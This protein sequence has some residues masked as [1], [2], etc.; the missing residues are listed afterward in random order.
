MEE[1]WKDIPDYE[2]LYQ[3]SSLGR[4][5][6]LK[7]QVKN[8]TGSYNTRKEKLLKPEI[9]NRGYFRVVLCKNG[10]IKRFS[11]HQLIAITFLNHKPCGM[12]L[13]VDHIDNNQ[14]NNKLQNLQ[15][16]TSRQNSSKEKRGNCKYTGVHFCARFGRWIA[17]IHI[18][19]KKRHLGYFKCETAAHLAYQ[20]RLN[21][22]L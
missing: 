8:P 2:G 3:A 12:D 5:K 16:I 18:N 9:T 6:G 22:I 17:R 7:R 21:T 14:T 20:K 11:V 10:K 13:V 15:V 1:I 4:I 19:G